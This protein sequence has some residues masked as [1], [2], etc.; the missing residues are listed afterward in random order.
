MS[1]WAERLR[2]ARRRWIDVGN[3]LEVQILRPQDDISDEFFPD[4][5]TPAQRVMAIAQRYVDDWRGMTEERLLPWVGG[6]A[7]VPF[8]PDV[9][10][11]WLPDHL[12]VAAQ[13]F[14]ACMADL[15]AWRQRIEDSTEK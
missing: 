12:D 3:G 7:N 8:D 13:V 5:M 15:K 14:D 11:E 1:V 2:A 10:R 4:A 6:D 9:W